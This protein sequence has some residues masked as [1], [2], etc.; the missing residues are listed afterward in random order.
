MA[1]KFRRVA[2]KPAGHPDPRLRQRPDAPLPRHPRTL[3]RGHGKPAGVFGRDGMRRGV[4]LAGEG[5]R[6]VRTLHGPAPGGDGEAD[7]RGRDAGAHSRRRRAG[8]GE[9]GGAPPPRRSDR[10]SRP[11]PGE[12]WPRGEA[13][14]LS[15]ACAG[16]GAAR[17]SSADHGAILAGDGRK[18]RWSCSSRRNASAF[19]GWVGICYARAAV[20]P[21]RGSSI[22]T[23]CPRGRIA[24][25]A[26]STTN[27]TS[28]AMSS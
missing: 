15:A 7:R 20:A 13:R 23:S 19:W 25:R 21:S 5:L 26:I 2:G 4:G 1:G 14:R 16:S 8:H 3:S 22:C 18:T 12:P 10:R 6:P 27:A 9:A 24:R 17:H 28:R 11:R